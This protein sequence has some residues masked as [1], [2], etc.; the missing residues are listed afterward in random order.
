MS[1]ALAVASVACGGLTEG[2]RQD[3][4]RTEPASE[5]GKQSG[6]SSCPPEGCQT[7]EPPPRWEEPAKCDGLPV[8]AEGEFE[9]PGGCTSNSSSCH[10]VTVCGVT[11]GCDVVCLGGCGAAEKAVFS[12][13][14]C[15][16]DLCRETTACG[17]TF[18]CTHA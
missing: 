7:P 1:A 17:R 13:S 10:D 16:N 14:E 8:C 12:P 18:W 6:G 5:N 3:S 2:E 4:A 11:L 9:I 15:F